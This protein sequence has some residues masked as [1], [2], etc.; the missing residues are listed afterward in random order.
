MRLYQKYD[1]YFY[2]EDDLKT[3]EFKRTRKFSN[4]IPDWSGTDIDIKVPLNEITSKYDRFPCVLF[5]VLPTNKSALTSF[6][7][8]SNSKYYIIKFAVSSNE[9]PDAYRYCIKMEGN[10]LTYHRFSVEDYLELF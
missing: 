3:V 1:L 7:K 2:S 10:H 5:T 8:M 9:I 4:G 6:D